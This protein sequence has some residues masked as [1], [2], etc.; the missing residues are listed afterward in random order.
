MNVREM[1]S[2]IRG[3][4]SPNCDF[5]HKPCTPEDLHPVSGGEW[6]CDTCMGDILDEMDGK[7]E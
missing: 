7:H 3:G 2:A 5:C 1:I 6:A 4:E